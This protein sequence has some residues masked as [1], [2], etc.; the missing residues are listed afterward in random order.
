MQQEETLMQIQWPMQ[1]RAWTWENE[2][3]VSVDIVGPSTTK[4]QNFVWSVVRQRFLSVQ[5]MHTPVT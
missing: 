1:E 4:E 2:G 3:L 5:Y